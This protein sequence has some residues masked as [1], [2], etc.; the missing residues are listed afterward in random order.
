MKHFFRSPIFWIDSTVISALL[1]LF[2]LKFFSQA[3]P[4]VNLDLTM[5]RTQALAYAKKISTQHEL[6]PDQYQQAT[7]FIADNAVKTFVELE[8]G[9]KDAF[10]DMMKRILCSIK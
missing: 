2:A 6:G 9:G 3:F 5:D 4:I 7:S 1:I 8:G 10:V